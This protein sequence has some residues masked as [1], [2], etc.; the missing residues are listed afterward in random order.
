MEHNRVDLF[1]LFLE[2]GANANRTCQAAKGLALLKAVR[3][4]NLY[5]VQVLAPLTGRVSCTRALGL[6]VGRQ[7]AAAVEALLQARSPSTEGGQQQHVRCDFEAAD[8]PLR[9][10]SYV[11]WTPNNDQYAGGGP[12]PAP[13]DFAPPLARA[14]RLGNAALVRV[15]LAHGADPNAG[16][17]DGARVAVPYG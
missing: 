16:Y 14:A 6:A 5:K 13:H 7:S 10:R 2:A 8:A 17:H 4:E 12:A 9:D 11:G 1:H 3:R 15:L